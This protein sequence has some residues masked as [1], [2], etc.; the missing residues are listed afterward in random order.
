[1]FCSCFKNIVVIFVRPII[2][3]STG[4]IFTKFAGF[5][6]LWPQINDVIFSISQGTLHCGNQFCWQNR[7]PSLTL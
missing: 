7:P 3:A 1:M 4:P 5:V 6:D 2:S